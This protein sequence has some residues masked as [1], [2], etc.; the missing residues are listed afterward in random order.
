MARRT[1]GLAIQGAAAGNLRSMKSVRGPASG[2]PKAERMPSRKLNTSHTANRGAMVSSPASSVRW[3]F[4]CQKR[5]LVSSIC[6]STVE[7][8][9]QHIYAK[10]HDPLPDHLGA[11][12]YQRRQA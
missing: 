11:A 2:W 5:R 9:R 7:L 6:V 8:F 3:K 10:A 4:G 1:S 12:L